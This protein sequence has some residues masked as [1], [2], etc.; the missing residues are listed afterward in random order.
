MSGGWQL[1][2]FR[3]IPIGLHWSMLVVF[4]LLVTS[5]ATSLFPVTHPELPDG[6]YWIIAVVCAVLFFG[7]ILLHELGH[8]LIAQRQGIKVRGIMLFVFGGVA[9]MASRSPSATIELKI[10][11]AGPIVSLT[12]A[13][14]FWM[15]SIL[16]AEVDAIAAPAT[17]LAGLNLIMALFNLLPGFPLDGGRILRAVVWRFSGSEDRATRVA[18]ASGHVFALGMMVLGVLLVVLGY[19]SNGIWLIV[20]GWFLRNA[21][22]TESTSTRVELALR[23]V[24]VAQALGTQQ[25]IVPGRMKLRQLV[26]DYVLDRG[27]S[28]FLVID[29]DV[30]RGIVTLRELRDVPQ[31]R[32]DWTSVADV[33]RPWNRLA[34]VSAQTPLQQAI[35]LMDTRGVYHLAV[36]DEGRPFGVLTREDAIHTIRL[37]MS[38]RPR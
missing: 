3:G 17:W 28:A 2:T 38:Q 30:P 15:V 1:G 37:R 4:A 14:L 23:G 26:E 6:A 5:L 18:Q 13:L 32:L 27:E 12:L 9:Q 19:V 10:A 8:S 25:T 22:A 16:F 36:T 7:S 11:V 20:L 31:S 21:A 24:T 29:D 35:E 34:V 33:M